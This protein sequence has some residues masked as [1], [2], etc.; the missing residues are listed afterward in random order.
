VGGWICGF[1]EK[2][3][4]CNGYI[5]ELWGMLEGLTLTKGYSA[6]EINVDSEVVAKVFQ[7]IERRTMEERRLLMWIHSFLHKSWE[8]RVCH[9]SIRKLPRVQT[10]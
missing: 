6:V 8:V 1:S 7:G 2:L 3:G 4:S 5:A 10:C 9:I